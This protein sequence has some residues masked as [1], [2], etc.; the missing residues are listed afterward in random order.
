[1]PCNHLGRLYVVMLW[2]HSIGFDRFC[3]LFDLFS[4]C[5][6]CPNSLCICCHHCESAIILR[7]HGHPL[8]T[9][10]RVAAEQPWPQFKKWLQNLGLNSA[11]K[12]TRRRCR[13]WMILL[14]YYAA[15]D[16]CVA[17]VEHNISDGAG[18][19]MP[20]FKTHGSG[21]SFEYALE[22]KLVKTFKF[23]LTLLLNKILLSDYC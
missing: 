13:K 16:W 5:C 23:S 11:T 22:H 20:A 4:V 2:Y 19:I 15:S 18:V 21:G 12:S 1:M 7:D 10:Q 8:W 17:G 14:Y 9:S 6:V 3:W